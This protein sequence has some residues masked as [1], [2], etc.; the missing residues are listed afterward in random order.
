MS[1]LAVAVVTMLAGCGGSNVAGST[2]PPEV[3]AELSPA[4]AR[5]SWWLGDWQTADGKGSEHWVAAGGTLYGVVLNGDYFEVMMIADGD[6]AGP[7]DGVLRLHAMP[8]GKRSVEFRQRT[9]GDA[10]ATFANEAYEF[11]KT[12]TYQLAADRGGLEAML[13]GGGKAMAFRWR[14]ATNQPAP[15][16]EAADRAFAADTAR[17]GASGWVAAFDPEGAMMRA[18]GRVEHA[19]IA[20][21]MRATLASGRLAWAPI[22]SG[23]AG[24]LGYTVGKATYTGATPADGWRSTYVTIWRHQPDGSWK[25]LFDTGRT[26]HAT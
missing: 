15:E 22:T 13:G 2:V 20:E 1:R 12:I 6:D 19:A 21:A 5:L 9:L 18:S 8:N 26:I 3:A 14:R 4:L 7:P 11:P 25:V 10:D 17:L 24:D 23:K 16:L